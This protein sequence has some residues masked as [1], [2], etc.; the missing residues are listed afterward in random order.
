MTSPTSRSPTGPA[1]CI[2]HIEGRAGADLAASVV[3]L[4]GSHR[5]Q[6]AVEPLLAYLLYADEAI[7]L[8][9]IGSDFEHPRPTQMGK[10]IRHCSRRST[11][12][13]RSSGPLRSNR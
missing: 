8:D 13:F 10:P 4:L 11:A 1:K 7:V 6:E 2:G 5:A 12:T 9:S 3:R